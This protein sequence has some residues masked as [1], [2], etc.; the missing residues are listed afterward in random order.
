MPLF[1][2]MIRVVWAGALLVATGGLV[3]TVIKSR[4][5]RGYLDPTFEALMAARREELSKARRDLRRQR[6]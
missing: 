1:L 5:D 6:P 4:N 2:V 3:A